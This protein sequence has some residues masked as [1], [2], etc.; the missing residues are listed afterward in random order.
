MSDMSFVAP[1][2]DQADFYFYNHIPVYMYKFCHFSE[3]ADPLWWRSYHTLELEFIFGSPFLDFMIDGGYPHNYT[4][5]DRRISKKMMRLWSN[6]I[7]H[8]FVNQRMSRL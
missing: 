6:F 5:E 2:V 4:D 7:K 3:L 1:A 8:G